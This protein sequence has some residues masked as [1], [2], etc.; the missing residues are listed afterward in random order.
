VKV[1]CL[2][3]PGVRHDVFRQYARGGRMDVWF[4]PSGS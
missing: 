1:P 2:S 3:R 4:V